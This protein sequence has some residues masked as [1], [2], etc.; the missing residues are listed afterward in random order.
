M[1]GSKLIHVNKRDPWWLSCRTP[2][3]NILTFSYISTHVY[4]RFSICFEFEGQFF[5]TMMLKCTSWPRPL[6]RAWLLR[7]WLLRAWFVAFH[8]TWI[9][10]WFSRVK[11]SRKPQ[12]TKTSS[13]GSVTTASLMIQSITSN[14]HWGSWTA[15]KT[16]FWITLW[17]LWPETLVSYH[18]WYIMPSKLIKCDLR[19]EQLTKCCPT[20]CFRLRLTR[21]FTKKVK[22]KYCAWVVFSY[23]SSQILFVVW[24]MN[25]VTQNC[26]FVITDSI[27]CFFSYRYSIQAYHNQWETP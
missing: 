20:V 22:Y 1:L 26:P 2:T 16:L 25:L 18:E 8:Y 14:G 19:Y 27:R 21:H 15:G 9:W 12:L 24:S 4:W 7:A 13:Q 3:D 11:I 10:S 23:T 6:L 17:F 5:S